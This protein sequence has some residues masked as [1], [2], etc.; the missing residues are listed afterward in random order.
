MENNSRLRKA[1]SYL[2]N[3]ISNLDAN[4][5]TNFCIKS[6]KMSIRN[7]KRLIKNTKSD[8]R[9]VKIERELQL[10]KEKY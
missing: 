8:M 1:M 5:M 2:N 10:I 9:I 6:A 4:P 7:A 3:A